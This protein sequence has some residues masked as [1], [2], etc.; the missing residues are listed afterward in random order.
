[1]GP[2]WNSPNTV[3]F[4]SKTYLFDEF[5]QRWVEK[6][7]AGEQTHMG[8]RLMKDLEAFHVSWVPRG[9]IPYDDVCCED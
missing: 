6:L 4:S 2:D 9:K 7:K 3:I 8:V 5:L 1:M